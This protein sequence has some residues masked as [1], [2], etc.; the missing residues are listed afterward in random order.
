M[1][2]RPNDQ[3]AHRA[4]AHL[5]KT[6]P[7]QVTMKTHIPSVL[8]LAAALSVSALIPLFAAPAPQGVAPMAYSVSRVD[9]NSSESITRGTTAWTILR[10][11][12]NPQQ[13]LSS[14]TWVYYGYQ[15]DFEPAND[16]QC[17]K[18]IFTMV[19]G[20]VADIKLVNDHAARLIAAQVKVKSTGMIASAK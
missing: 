11:L 4:H 10:C 6:K 3:P 17:D 7:S 19:R 14:D 8:I 13:K 9:L 1:T 15:A 20:E 12:G 2:R 5:I 18:L 16:Q